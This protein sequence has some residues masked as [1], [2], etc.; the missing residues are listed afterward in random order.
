MVGKWL[1]RERGVK[2]SWKQQGAEERGG[3]GGQEGH[4]NRE[5]GSAREREG[6]GEMEMKT[7]PFRMVE[8]E[9]SKAMLMRGRG[10]AP[11]E[12]VVCIQYKDKYI[13]V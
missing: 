3:R 13:H 12:Q 4:E 7:G 10:D 9:Q 11:E 1:R 8:G 6:G 5:R 2:I